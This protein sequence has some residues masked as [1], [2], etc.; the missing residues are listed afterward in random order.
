MCYLPMNILAEASRQPLYPQDQVT[1]MT[2]RVHD[3]FVFLVFRILVAVNQHH[4]VS[5]E[6]EQQAA[7]SR[8]LIP[9]PLEVRK[10]RRQ[11]ELAQTPRSLSCLDIAQHGS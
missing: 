9:N 2:Q 1:V 5:L 10:G 7:M 6:G 3:Q 8:Q 11:R 4:N